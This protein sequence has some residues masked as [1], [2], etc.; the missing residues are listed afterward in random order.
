MEPAGARISWPET[1]SAAGRT[2]RF[3]RSTT[4]YGHTLYYSDADYDVAD[5]V[6]SVAAR[7]QALPIQVALAW[8]LRQP[9]VTAPIISVTKREQLEQLIEA[10]SVRL[11]DED[12][13]EVQ[14][15]YRPHPVLGHQ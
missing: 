15:P 7:R 3:A 2:R 11:S 8:I 14:S 6:A 12:A 9:G 4:Q 10:M 1:G 5:R 13:A